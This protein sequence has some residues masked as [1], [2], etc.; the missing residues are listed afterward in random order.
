M[1]AMAPVFSVFVL[2]ASSYQSTV[3]QLPLKFSFTSE[4]LRCLV[5]EMSLLLKL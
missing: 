2:S 1:A 5:L 4:N 3:F